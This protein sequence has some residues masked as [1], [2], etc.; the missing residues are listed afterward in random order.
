MAG[1]N[2]AIVAKVT[3]WMAVVAGAAFLTSSLVLNSEAAQETQSEFNYVSDRIDSLENG[4]LDG[5]LVDASAAGAAQSDASRKPGPV[6]PQAVLLGAETRLTLPGQT[7]AGVADGTYNVDIERVPNGSA[8][9]K[10]RR[11]GE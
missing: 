1:E 5:G 9:V 3:V 7:M 4:R 10:V 11:L 2:L 6:S 8:R